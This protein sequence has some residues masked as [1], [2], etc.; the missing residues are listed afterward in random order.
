M[1]KFDRGMVGTTDQPPV[2]C[3]YQ[4]ALRYDIDDRGWPVSSPDRWSRHFI[5]YAFHAPGQTPNIVTGSSEMR[6]SM[7]APTTVAGQVSH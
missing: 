7:M 3:T 6:L 1:S 4:E 5:E 2:L